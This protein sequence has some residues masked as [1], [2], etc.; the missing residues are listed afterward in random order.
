MSGVARLRSPVFVFRM[1]P[2][3]GKRE[4]ENEIGKARAAA[5]SL[6]LPLLMINDNR[7][8]GRKK[9]KNSE[10]VAVA[11]VAG[12]SRRRHYSGCPSGLFLL[13]LALN[14][15]IFRVIL[16]VVRAVGNQSRSREES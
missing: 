12:T 7:E 11:V 3:R 14:L 13:A 6:L 5:R 16:C 1:N 10:F 9:K 4:R 8:T 15:L 2:S